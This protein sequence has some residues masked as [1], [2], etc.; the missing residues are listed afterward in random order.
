M[1]VFLTRALLCCCLSDWFPT[2]AIITIALYTLRLL[3]S[4][5]RSMEVPPLSIL[6]RLL[7]SFRD[8]PAYTAERWSIFM[9]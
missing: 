7:C 2:P 4:G 5:Y 9:H 8:Q 3:R 1:Y 6:P